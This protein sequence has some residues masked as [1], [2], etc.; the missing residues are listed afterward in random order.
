MD[1]DRNGLEVLDLGTCLQL[2]TT[3]PIVRLGVTIEALPVVLPVN[4]ALADDKLLVRT[5]CGTKLS[6]ALNNAVV[7]V[8]ADDYDPLGHTGWSVLIQGIARLVDEDL[9]PLDDLPAVRP[10]SVTGEHLIAISTEIVSGRRVRHDI[11][12]RVPPLLPGSS[13][14]GR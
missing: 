5:G 3:V 11:A 13:W 12:P 10:W 2:L 4:F 1:L 14:P 9:D 8:E 6:A 7:A